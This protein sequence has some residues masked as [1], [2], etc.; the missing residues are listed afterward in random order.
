MSKSKPRQRSIPIHRESVFS[1]PSPVFC[2][3]PLA[4]LF[5]CTSVFSA[6]W[7]KARRRRVAI[8]FVPLWPSVNYAKQTQF[9]QPQNHRNQLCRK[10][11]PQYPTPPTDKK[12]TQTNPIPQRNTQYAIRNTRY[13]PKQTQSH[14][15][16]Q[17]A[18]RDTTSLLRLVEDEVFYF[19]AGQVERPVCGRRCA[20]EVGVGL[21]GADK[22][23]NA[24]NHL[25]D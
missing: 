21:L 17:Y 18:I 3:C 6:S 2:L 8:S 15:D 24:V 1:L 19:L 22:R 12:Q 25:I 10:D 4:P 23:I 14:R 13:K 20:A 7:P 5:L 9:P 16:T 11:L